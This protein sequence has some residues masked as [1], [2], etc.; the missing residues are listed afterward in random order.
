[1]AALDG[2][3]RRMID[4]GACR[5]LIP[6]LPNLGLTPAVAAFGTPVV[7]SAQRLTLAYNHALERMLARWNGSGLAELV[8]VDVYAE[9]QRMVEG[10]SEA[11]ASRLLFHDAMHPAASVHRHIATIAARAILHGRE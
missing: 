11:G 10:R 5:F 1:M 6:N 8:L 9:V 3:V 2:I 7:R 4:A